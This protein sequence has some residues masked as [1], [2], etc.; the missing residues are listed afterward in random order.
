MS[1]DNR[2]IIFNVSDITSLDCHIRR[3]TNDKIK[4]IKA[5]VILII[6]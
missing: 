1:E 2:F 5:L 3:V 4:F 6:G